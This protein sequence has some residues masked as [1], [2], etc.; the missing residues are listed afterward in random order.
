MA[1]S[2]YKALVDAFAADIRTGRLAAGT[3]LPTHRGLA[4]REGIAVVTATRVYAELAAM[5]LVS[6]EQGR[7]TFVRDIAVP[8]GHGIDQ[9]AV[10]T[11]AVDLSFNCPSLPGQADLL[12]QAL[13]EVAT[14]GDLDSL[15]RYQPHRGRPQDRASV[16]RHLTRRGIST[17]ADRILITNGAQQ[18]L[19]V[20]VMALLGAGDVVAVDALTYPGFKVLAHAFRLDLEPV[21]TTADGPDLDALERLCAT[22]PVRAIHTMPTLHNPLG[23]VMSA[24]DRTRLAGIARRHGALIVEDAS[25]A[26]LVEDPPPPLAAIAPDITIHVSG[27]SKSVAT[28]LRVGF[29]VAPP[30]VVPSLERAI[31]ATTWNT[32]ALTTAIACRW[33]DDGTVDDLETRKRDDA[34]ARQALARQELAGLPLVGHPSSYFTWLPLPDDARADRLTATLARQHISVSTAEP[35]TTT[36]HTPQAI[37]LALGSTDLDSLRTTLRTV[38]RVAA[39]DAHA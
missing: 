6:R 25:Y 22:R 34:K 12:R 31:R 3:R 33:L 1:A 19:A 18:G 27:L 30:S 36:A 21:P 17:N 11:D 10:A 29:V 4:A 23:W 37:R 15:L 26:Y 32:P 2:R 35:F 24:A 9:Q 7:G 16:A 38:R 5:G 20:T 13:R 14:S 28:G 39:E 8:A